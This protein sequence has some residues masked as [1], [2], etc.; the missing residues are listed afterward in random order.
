MPVIIIIIPDS[1]S[2]LISKRNSQLRELQAVGEV[3][4]VD[5]DGIGSLV[6]VGVAV[7]EE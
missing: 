7:A 6:D 4:S 3:E 2:Q 5:V 1:S